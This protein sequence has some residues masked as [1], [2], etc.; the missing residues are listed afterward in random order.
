MTK[1]ELKTF[2]ALNL[3]MGLVNRPTLVSYWSTDQIFL[4]PFFQK[5]FPSIRFTQIL[6]YLHFVDNKTLAARGEEGYD[7]LGKIRPFLERV[8]GRFQHVYSPSRN[9]SVE[10]T[11]IKF[12]GH[13][14]WRQFM[15]DK[16]ARF[17]LKKVTPADS[18]NGCVLHIIVYTGKENA[19]DSKGLA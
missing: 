7:K 8:I 6:R 3:A 16:P 4:T 17:G 19:A 5:T 14:S 13:L 15:K 12:K 2:L 9:L 11:L 18:A 10:E 1:D